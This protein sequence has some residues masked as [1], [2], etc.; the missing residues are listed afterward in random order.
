LENIGLKQFILNI[1]SYIPELM[2]NIDNSLKE[3]LLNK[4]KELNKKELSEFSVVLMP[5]FFVDHFLY[6]DE[7]EN[8]YDKIK[9]TYSQGGG[10]LP[11]VSQIIHQGGN[12]ANTSLTLAKLGIKTNLICRTNEFGLHLLEFF[13]G[14]EGV[15]LSRVKTN[16]KLAITTAMEFGE[17]HVNVMVGD[18]GSVSDFS[19][20][21]LGER[22]FQIISQSNMVC[23]L[24]WTLNNY[25]T[26]LA[27]NVLKFAKNHNVKT[28]FD[29]GDPS[30]QKDKI[31][32]LKTIYE[33]TKMVNST[34]ELGKILSYV[35][36]FLVDTIRV[37]NSS[38]VILECDNVKDSF[39]YKKDG[40]SE[41]C[42]LF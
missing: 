9:N 25:G 32:E 3:R 30:P 42:L 16:G 40:R 37:K 15:D 14:L 7:F 20:N 13:L 35:L 22:D 39:Y 24:N 2:T 8:A 26:E 36:K 12:A 23:V 29:A 6:L 1:C 28:F 19:S 11:G 18:T 27:Q 5:D 21:M 33:I 41:N 38:I 34:L 31:S 4:L 10:N 17:K